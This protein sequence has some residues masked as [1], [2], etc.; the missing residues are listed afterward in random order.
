MGSLVNFLAIIVG[1]LAGLVLKDRF[2]PRYQDIALKALG[3]SSMVIGLQMALKVE[4]PLIMISSMVVGGFLGEWIDIEKA[5]KRFAEWIKA[6][7]NF[8]ESQF[9]TGFMTASLIY[10]VG[11]M[12]ILGALEDGIH[13]N[14]SILYMKSLLDGITSIALAATMG[15]GVVLS[16]IP[17]LIYQGTI[18]ILSSQ[19]AGFFVDRAMLNLS[20]TGGLLIMAISLNM[21]GITQLKVGNLLPAIFIA[22]TIGA[23]I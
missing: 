18:S 1:G 23:L 2:G 3:L 16:A 19:L 11:S 8:Q 15:I 6:R 22:A 20:S 12:A 9:V 17:V 10:C 7:G 13:N 21:L 5:L 14:P 4:N